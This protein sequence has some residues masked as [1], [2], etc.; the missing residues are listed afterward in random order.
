MELKK[1]ILRHKCAVGV[2]SLIVIALIV[3]IG[4]KN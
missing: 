3:G 1:F 4:E 2:A